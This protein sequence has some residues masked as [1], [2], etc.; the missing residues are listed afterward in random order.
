MYMS[1]RAIAVLLAVCA[2]LCMFLPKADAVVSLLSKCRYE[3]AEFCHDRNDPVKCLSNAREQMPRG[4]TC[5]T[6][7]EAHHSCFAAVDA[8]PSCD[9][10]VESKRECLVKLLEEDLPMECTDSEYYRIVKLET[11]RRGVMP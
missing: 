3:H 4:S 1:K 9:R 2:F 6:W 7:L 11:P 5:R 10:E 8:N